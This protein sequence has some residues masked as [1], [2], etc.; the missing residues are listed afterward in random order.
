MAALHITSRWALFLRPMAHRFDLAFQIS[1]LGRLTLEQIVRFA[2]EVLGR[3]HQRCAIIADIDLV[4]T[5]VLQQEIVSAPSCIAEQR[6]VIITV[7]NKCIMFPKKIKSFCT[8]SSAATSRA[9]ERA[10][11][12]SLLEYWTMPK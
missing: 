10:S 5:L 9:K 3:D 11:S 4:G 7:Q 2:I 6:A 1:N 8:P 12:F